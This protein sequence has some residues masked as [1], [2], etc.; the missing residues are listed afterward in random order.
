MNSAE[1]KEGAFNTGERKASV[2]R[3]EG[4]ISKSSLQQREGEG[5]KFTERKEEGRSLTAETG[6]SSRLKG[7]RQLYFCPTHGHYENF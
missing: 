7:S 4:E 1:R 2:G 6:D 5:C 3:R